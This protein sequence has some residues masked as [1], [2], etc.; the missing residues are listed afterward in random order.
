MTMK[1]KIV[2]CQAS[3]LQIIKRNSDLHGKFMHPISRPNWMGLG[4]RKEWYNGLMLSFE[5]TRIGNFFM[6]GEAG[7]EEF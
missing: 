1:F 5:D 2:I 6:T 3:T 7:N 4:I